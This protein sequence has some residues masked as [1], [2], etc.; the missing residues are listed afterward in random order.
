VRP[1]EEREKRERGLDDDNGG[2]VGG[3]RRGHALK[4]PCGRI[5]GSGRRSHVHP[6]RRRQ[7]AHRGT[8]RGFPVAQIAAERN[9]STLAVRLKVTHERRRVMVTETSSK[10]TAMGAECLCRVTR[11]TSAASCASTVSAIRL[12][13]VSI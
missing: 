13:A 5:H 11:T 1:V 3:R 8:Q 12:A 6:P 4:G 10:G 2:Q 9:D 7:L